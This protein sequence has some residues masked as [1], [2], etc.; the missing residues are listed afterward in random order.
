MACDYVAGRLATCGVL[1]ALLRRAEEGGSYRVVVSLS[2]MALWLAEL[3]I[4][5]RG[6]VTKA[7]GSNDEHRCPDPDTFV[8][9]TPMGR[10]SG[11][12][13]VVEMS[14]T[15]GDYKDLCAF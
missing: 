15:P 10:Y 5:D 14:K 7:A 1:L 13:E 4:F 12:R 3:G 6:Y 11:V 9:D 2:R 8:V